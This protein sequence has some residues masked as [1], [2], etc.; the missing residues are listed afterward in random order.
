MSKASHIAVALG[1]PLCGS[2]IVVWVLSLPPSWWPT[3]R[4]DKEQIR[5]VDGEAYVPVP[6]FHRDSDDAPQ[7]GM[8]TPDI[9]YRGIRRLPLCQE[10][11]IREYRRRAE[12]KRNGLPSGAIGPRSQALNGRPL[13]FFGGVKV[14][15]RRGDVGVAQ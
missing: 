4:E 15:G 6:V 3:L 13:A 1:I 14:S 10:R 5:P 11:E 12:P 8:G 7:P 2:L 9:G